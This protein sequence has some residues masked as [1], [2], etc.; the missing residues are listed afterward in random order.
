M[1][2]AQ[3][4]DDFARLGVGWLWETNSQDRFTDFSVKT[5][6]ASKLAPAIRLVTTRETRTSL[7]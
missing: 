4:Y 1:N 6:Q 7:A 3:T 5:S 2:D